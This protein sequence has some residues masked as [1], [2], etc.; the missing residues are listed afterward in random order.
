MNLSYKKKKYLLVTFFMFFAMMTAVFFAS[1]HTQA[2]AASQG[3]N[4]RYRTQ[5]EIRSYVAANRA[6]IGDNFSFSSNPFLELPYDPGRLSDATQ[7]S[8][9]NM[10]NLLRSMVKKT[11]SSP[12]NIFLFSLRNSS[13]YIFRRIHTQW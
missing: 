9:L 2:H 8:A 12:V 4:V 1:S 13:F 7:Q 10:L 5:Q 11:E 3:M 6:G